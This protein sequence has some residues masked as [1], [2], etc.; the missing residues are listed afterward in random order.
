M[1]DMAP[2]FAF[3]AFAAILFLGFNHRAHRDSD[4]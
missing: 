3:W 2:L 1:A 4:I